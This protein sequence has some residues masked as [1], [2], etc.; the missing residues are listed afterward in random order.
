[1]TTE[2]TYSCRPVFSPSEKLLTPPERRD[3][4]HGE[5]DTILRI[6][7]YNVLVR[8]PAHLR[9]ALRAICTGDFLVLNRV[10]DKS[11]RLLNLLLDSSTERAELRIQGM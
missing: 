4:S 3:I 7:E 10:W 1:M 11:N 9:V 5:D 6:I 8:P 2:C